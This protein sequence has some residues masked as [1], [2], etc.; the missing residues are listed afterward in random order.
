MGILSVLIAGISG[1]IFGAIWYTVFATRWMAV[2]GVAL[3][4]EGKPINRSNPVPYITSLVGCILVAGMMRHTFVL[5]GIDT[6]GEGF[7][8]GLG[9]GLFLVTPW[10]ATFY[11]FGGKPRDLVLIDGGY[12]TFGSTVIATVLT[13]F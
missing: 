11:A 10:I 1:F 8:A 4:A 9:I 3:D 6:P 7:V 5:S 2:S 13:L 12:A